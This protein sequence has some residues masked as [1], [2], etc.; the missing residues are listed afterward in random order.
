MKNEHMI[1]IRN[2][3]FVKAIPVNNTC[4]TVEFPKN[5]INGSEEPPIVINYVVTSSGFSMY[6]GNKE[7]HVEAKRYLV[8]PAILAHILKEAG[9]RRVSSQLIFVYHNQKLLNLS[10]MLE[11]VDMQLPEEEKAIEARLLFM[12]PAIV[13]GDVAKL[14]SDEDNEFLCTFL[15]GGF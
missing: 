15:S 5:M 13:H 1:C 10:K 3:F 4:C 7:K 6:C 14:E 8:R 12:V 9:K 11:M 2:G